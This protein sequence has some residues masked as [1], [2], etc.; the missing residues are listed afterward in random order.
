MF[1]EYNKAN[2][3]HMRISAKEARPE[4][5][6]SVPKVPVA[7]Q[8]ELPNEKSMNLD[9]LQQLLTRGKMLAKVTDGDGDIGW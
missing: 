9:E 8:V 2:G 7:F 5:K 4:I 3:I 1:K 6:A